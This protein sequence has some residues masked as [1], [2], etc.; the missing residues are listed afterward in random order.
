MAYASK[1]YVYAPQFPTQEL[2]QEPVLVIDTVPSAPGL[3]GH[4]S[5]RQP[6]VINNLITQFLGE[7]E[8]LAVVRDDGDVDAYRIRHI[9]NAI[10]KRFDPDSSL[11][12]EA[13]DI[14]PF[15]QRNVG[16]SAWG[17]AIHSAARMI[18]VSSNNLEVT[19]F[20][21]ALV[22]DEAVGLGDE[23]S[24]DEEHTYRSTSGQKPPSDRRNND[25]RIIQNGRANIPNITF[26]NTGHDPTG[27]WLLSTDIAGVVRSWNVH[28]LSP[29]E[30]VR[31]NVQ[32][33]FLLYS[34]SFDA[35]NSGW[36]VM[37][38]DPQSF[39]T[40]RSVQQALGMSED[41]SVNHELPMWDLSKSIAR[42]VGNAPTFV[43]TRPLDVLDGNYANPTGGPVEQIQRPSSIPA[44]GSSS[45]E[46]FEPED[47]EIDID[48]DGNVDSDMES[49]DEDNIDQSQTLDNVEAATDQIGAEAAQLMAATDA[50][51]T[52][53]ENATVEEDDHAIPGIG[54][55][56]IGEDD[57]YDSD[58]S[59]VEESSP[60]A[61]RTSK[62]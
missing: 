35:L 31:A 37:F 14:K 40:T 58:D 1:I 61:R 12:I 9:Y 32:P 60:S 13:T 47:F 23:F 10:E 30:A 51:R 54:Q 29:G 34:D 25:T 59:Y 22:Q 6:H 33:H 38:L 48:S 53:V 55:H 19:I 50:N 57:P 5:R 46:D 16:K 28:T 36:T 15:F 26:C 4:I 44:D 62:M 21:F 45:S 42:V 52:T 3:Q 27:E 39:C 56:D 41:Q 18:A 11:G 43:Q 24:T 49:E 20:T 7:E 17:L 8:V 2:G